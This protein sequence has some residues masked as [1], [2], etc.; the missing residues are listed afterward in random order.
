MSTC[1]FMSIRDQSH[2]LTFVQGHS[3][4]INFKLLSNPTG[5]VEAE[6]HVEPPWGGEAKMCSNGPGHMTKMAAKRIYVKKL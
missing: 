1:R 4:F 5:P 2:S 6:F 3:D